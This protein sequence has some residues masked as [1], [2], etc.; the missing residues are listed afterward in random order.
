MFEQ[1]ESGIELAN[2]NWKVVRQFVSERYGIGL[3]RSSSELGCTAW[4]SCCPKPGWST[5]WHEAYRHG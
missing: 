2:W 3:S 4:D 1:D 5:L